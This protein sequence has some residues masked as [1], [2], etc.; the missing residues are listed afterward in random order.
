MEEDGDVKAPPTFSWM[1][2]GCEALADGEYDA[3]V[4]GTG[5]KVTC[6]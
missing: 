5:L 2:E 1:P 4:M 6:A 3:I